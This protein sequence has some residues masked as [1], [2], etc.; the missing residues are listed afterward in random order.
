VW[1]VRAFASQASPTGSAARPMV[2]LR[3]RRAA[4][5][6]PVVLIFAARLPSGLAGAAGEPWYKHEYE[7]NFLETLTL[8]LLVLLA[9]TFEATWHH[10]VHTTENAYRYGEFEKLASED[11]EDGPPAWVERLRLPRGVMSHDGTIRHVRLLQEVV[12]RA[13]GE[14]MTLGFLAFAT[15]TC[16]QLGGFEALA[17]RMK[18]SASDNDDWRY[19]TTKEDWLHTAENVHMQLFI[20]MVFYFCLMSLTAAGTVKKIRMW[21]Q[22]KL[23]SNLQGRRTVKL[24]AV[25]TDLA[26]HVKWRDYFLIRMSRLQASCPELFEDLGDDLGLDPW[27]PNFPD[28]FRACLE[29]GFPFST[30][31]TVN[32]ERGVRDAIQVHR[33][34]WVLLLVALGILSMLHRFGKVPI[35]TIMPILVFVATACLVTMR[36]IIRMT[37]RK[38]DKQAEHM[39]EQ[40]SRPS[41]KQRRWLSGTHNTDLVMLRVLQATLF[42]LSYSLSRTVMD[43]H[44]WSARTEETLLYTSVFSIIFFAIALDL[45]KSVPLFTGM[46]AMPPNMDASKF[47]LFCAVFLQARH[48][49]KGERLAD[50]YRRLTSVEVAPFVRGTSHEPP[51][52]GELFCKIVEEAREGGVTE[53]ELHSRLALLAR[54]V[55]AMQSGTEADTTDSERHSERPVPEAPAPLAPVTRHWI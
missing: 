51:K 19:P 45:P 47:K 13:G 42:L 50:L 35:M 55:G 54:Q 6:L 3:R 22:C 37:M 31:I 10:F 5:K 53:D 33:T 48:E 44:D 2:C 39:D 34:S 4:S 8:M 24:D 9:L 11:L 32:V 18:E 12:S 38:F 46:M 36:I 30:Y 25:D 20:A 40:S 17:K 16:N 23:R 52:V 28:K 41:Q 49:R 1:L 27:A 26:V 43:F 29:R 7:Y 14:F 21:E 15:Y